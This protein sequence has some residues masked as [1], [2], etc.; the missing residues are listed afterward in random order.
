[1]QGKDY[2]SP[3]DAYDADVA[4]GQ[5]SPV[6]ILERE[7]YQLTMAAQCAKKRN[8]YATAI[9]NLKQIAEICHRQGKERDA[10]LLE[11]ESFLLEQ[12][13][14]YKRA[15]ISTAAF[16]QMP[17]AE[18]LKTALSEGADWAIAMDQVGYA[19]A[20][21]KLNA[22]ICRAQGQEQN[23]YMLEHDG[24][25]LLEDAGKA[26]DWEQIPSV[27]MEAKCLKQIAQKYG[28]TLSADN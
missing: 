8:D 22:R 23:A 25:M 16:A 20:F 10:Y 27:T 4:R 6:P 19:V 21:K 12:E 7:K 26:Y 3:Y 5:I 11:H 28:D 15:N 9:R 18:K 17:Y 14:I 24:Y 1:M 2:G 13:L